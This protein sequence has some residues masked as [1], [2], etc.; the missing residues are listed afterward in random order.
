M[1]TSRITTDS[2][3]LLGMNRT[4]LFIGNKILIFETYKTDDVLEI[5]TWMRMCGVRGVS[6]AIRALTTSETKQLYSLGAARIVQ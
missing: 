4:A 5:G 3:V 2:D 1:S 6:D